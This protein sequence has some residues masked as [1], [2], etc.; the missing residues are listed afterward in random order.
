[1]D[2]RWPLRK[3]VSLWRT[4]VPTPLRGRSAAPVAARITASAGA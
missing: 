2:L 4:C 1:M 3:A